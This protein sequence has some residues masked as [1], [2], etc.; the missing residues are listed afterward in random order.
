[1]KLLTQSDR[2]KLARNGQLADRNPTWTPCRW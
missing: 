2:E 1:M